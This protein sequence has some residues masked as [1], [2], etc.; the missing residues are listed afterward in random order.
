MNTEPSVIDYQNVNIFLADWFSY[1]K[2]IR[3]GFSFEVWSKQLGLSSR[4]YLQ[5][6]VKGKRS[7]SPEIEDLICEYFDL[8][9]EQNQHLR[10]LLSL[11]KKQSQKQRLKILKKLSDRQQYYKNLKKINA[12]RLFLQTPEVS[13]L[14]TL[15]SFNDLDR[16]EDNLAKILRLNSDKLK[17][18]LAVLQDLGLA[19]VVNTKSKK[20]WEATQ[21]SFRVPK[22][23]GNKE[24]V[25]FHLNSLKRSAEL[26][27]SV[28]TDRIAEC[29]LLPLN[30]SE[31]SELVELLDQFMSK[32]LEKYQSSSSLQRKLYRFQTVLVPD[33]DM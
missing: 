6:I 5:Q 30:K 26:F 25:Q 11:Q 8:P 18:A 16:A 14:C 10:D 12:S 9:S 31:Y 28:P 3:R 32:C 17:E 1:K 15:L 20:I 24:L 13:L 2:T 22:E 7:I 23:I 21:E 4:A 29:M 19:K 27:C 33:A